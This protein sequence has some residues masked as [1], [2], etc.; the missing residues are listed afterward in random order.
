MFL[1]DADVHPREGQTGICPP[2]SKFSQHLFW[3]FW[4]FWNFWTISVTTLSEKNFIIWGGR[5]FLCP[6]KKIFYLHPWFET[7]CHKFNDTRNIYYYVHILVMSWIS[8]KSSLM[9]SQ[10]RVIVDVKLIMI[11]NYY[12]YISSWGIIKYFL[13]Y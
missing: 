8:S 2:P 10:N 5:I 1:F 7:L 3:H 11:I 9:S 6:P 4:H 12:Y 13:L